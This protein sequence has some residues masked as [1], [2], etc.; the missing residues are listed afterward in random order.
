MVETIALRQIA[1]DAECR[2]HRSLQEGLQVGAAPRRELAL[3][4]IETRGGIHLLAL[5]QNLNLVPGQI[6]P[7]G[8]IVRRPTLGLQHRQADHHPHRQ[9]GGEGEGEQ[10]FQSQAHPAA[11]S[12]SG[13]AGRQG[14]PERVPSSRR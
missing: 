4:L 5:D 7:A 12:M 3:D 8:G 11:D 1:H 6:E 2:R 14:A 13:S 9:Q 10:Q